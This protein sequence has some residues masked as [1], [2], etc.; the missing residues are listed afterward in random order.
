MQHTRW[1]RQIFRAFST[2][3]KMH[4]SR[5]VMKLK[6]IQADYQCED[7][8]PI[9]L[10]GGFFDRILYTSTLVLCFVGFCSTC[11]TIYDL[12]KPPSWKTKAC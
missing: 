10:K 7:G 12:A 4:D 9:Y 2:T 6:K 8:R 5:A 11:A 3:P 1:S